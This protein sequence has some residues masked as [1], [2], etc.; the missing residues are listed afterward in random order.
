MGPR[1][2]PDATIQNV[3]REFV[4]ERER[5]LPLPDSRLYRHVLLFLEVC[6]NNYG[7]RNLDEEG[8][9]WYERLYRDENSGR[10]HFYELFGPDLLLSELG[11]FTDR[12]LKTDVHTTEKVIAGAGRVVS[13]LKSWLVEKGYVSRKSIE[14]KDREAEVRDRLIRRVRPVLRKMSRSLV[15]V[16]PS[17]LAGEDSVPLDDHLVS[18]VE[19]ARV[20]LRVHRC[21]T[22][23]EIGPVELPEELTRQLRPGFTLLCSVARLRGRWRLTEI[24]EVHPNGII[25]S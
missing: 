14:Q 18:R 11:F 7:H 15:S 22:P 16:E 24:E 10:R 17:T 9:D 25:R 1:V 5:R 3:L 21:A 8:R 4:E 19:P 20:W 6:I 2:A 13:D 23:E 12:F